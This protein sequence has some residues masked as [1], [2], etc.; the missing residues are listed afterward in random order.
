MEAGAGDYTAK[1]E[2]CAANGH[3][4]LKGR[5]GTEDRERHHQDAVWKEVNGFFLYRDFY[6]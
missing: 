2:D 1:A 3:P 5:R 6:V 4:H